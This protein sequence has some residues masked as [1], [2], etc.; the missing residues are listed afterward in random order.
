MSESTKLAAA[1]SSSSDPDSL[2]PEKES[3]YTFSSVMSGASKGAEMVFDG[4]LCSNALASPTPARSATAVM[5]VIAVNF[6]EVC[7]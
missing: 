3:E 6:L 5:A 4:A 2:S 7:I 1:I